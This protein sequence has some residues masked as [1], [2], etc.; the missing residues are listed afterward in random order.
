MTPTPPLTDD[1]IAQIRARHRII[2]GGTSESLAGGDIKALLGDV[3]KLLAEVDR[4]RA[5]E[6]FRAEAIAEQAAQ[7]W[8]NE[9]RI[10]IRAAFDWMSLGAANCWDDQMS[11]A[12]D[13]VAADMLASL[14]PEDARRWRDLNEAGARAT[15]AEAERDEA[16]ARTALAASGD[17]WRPISDEAKTGASVLVYGL[18]Q[19]IEGVVFHKPAVFTAHWDAIDNSFCLDGGTWLGPFVEPTHWMP[20]PAS[21][22]EKD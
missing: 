22:I 14:S 1:Y 16:R 19:S 15:Q 17:G 21:P 12:L 10:A 3:A 18:P 4:L 13:Q 2:S 20:K 7:G 9:Q 8:T 11:N 5:S 6:R